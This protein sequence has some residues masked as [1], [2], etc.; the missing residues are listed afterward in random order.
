MAEFLS[1]PSVLTK[2]KLKSALVANNVALPNGDQRKGV[3]VELYLKNLTSQNK[4]SGSGE[5]FSSDEEPPAPAASI[6]ARSGRK[7][8]KK[9][10]RVRPEEIDVTELTNEDLKDQLLKYGVNAGPIVASTRKVYEKKLQKLLDQ[11]PPQTTVI[12]VAETVST[13]NSRNGNVDSDQYS[14]K[15]EETSATVQEPEL[16]L[17]LEPVPVVERPL[18]SRGKTPVTTRTR[19]SQNKKEEDD[20]SEEE[21]FQVVN[22]ERKSRR[23]CRHLDHAVPDPVSISE[24]L[25]VPR[26]RE[27]LSALPIDPEPLL[28]DKLP[29]FPESPELCMASAHTSL[30]DHEKAFPSA[31]FSARASA[32]PKASG[33][34]ILLNTAL[35]EERKYVS[36]H[37][38]T[39]QP[40]SPCLASAHPS[41][42]LIHMMCRL[43]PSRS[44]DSPCSLNL[45][46][47]PRRLTHDLPITESSSDLKEQSGGSAAVQSRIDGFFCPV[48]PIRG[49]DGSL[50]DQTPGDWIE[51]LSAVEQTPKTAEKDVLKELFPNEV[52]NTPTGISATCRRPIKG[53][54]S[55]PYSDTLQEGLRPRLT[56][57]RYTSSSFT[58]TR[59]VPHVRAVSAVPRVSAVPLS[60]SKPTVPLSVQTKARRRLPVWVQLLLLVAVSGFL[61]FVYQAMESNQLNPF[62]QP[63]DS[64]VV[65]KARK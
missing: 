57:H 9:T 54:A 23:S 31:K 22:V 3:Y 26:E 65:G 14:D 46:D 10:D 39:K 5:A 35:L 40:S 61:L 25:P 16:E 2:D 60:V 11:G 49:Q 6:T 21:D 20:E 55:R 45:R 44:K 7:A 63:G 56:E 62:G 19:S 37:S 64:G 36:P 12:S 42:D 30:D 52:L 27:K 59:S 50:R 58:E 1:D 15:E 34:E 8:T 48:T 43:S 4:K 17:E 53:A 24:M 18:R 28:A 38:R 13:H 29:V 51:K 47:S 33:E 32:L 41:S